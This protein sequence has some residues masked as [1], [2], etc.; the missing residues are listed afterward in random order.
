VILITSAVGG[1]G[2]TKLAVQLARGLARAQRRIVLVDFDLRQPALDEALGLP[3][4]PGICEALRGDGEIM[5]MVRQPENE[6]FSVVTA[7]FCNQQVLVDFSSGA[8][9]KVL[10]QLRTNFDFGIIDSSPPLP[11]V[12]TRLVCQHVDAVVLLVFRDISQSSKVQAAHEMLVAF[13]VRNVE[14]AVVGG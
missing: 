14:I 10:E 2:K 3:L 9:A 6:R 13:G 8:P 7:G 1:E 5:A 4:G 12:D 11:T